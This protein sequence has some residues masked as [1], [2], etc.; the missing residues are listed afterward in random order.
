LPGDVTSHRDVEEEVRR[1]REAE[2]CVVANCRGLGGKGVKGCKQEGIEEKAPASLFRI[3]S[4]LLHH[5]E[6]LT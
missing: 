2:G 6:L 4:L 1:A 3:D 5:V